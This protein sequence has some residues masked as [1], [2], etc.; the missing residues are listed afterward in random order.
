M[1]EGSKQRRRHLH[2]RAISLSIWSFVY[3]LPLL[4]LNA[5][6][7]VCLTDSMSH[8]TH[9][10]SQQFCPHPSYHAQSTVCTVCLIWCCKFCA[11]VSGRMCVRLSQFVHFSCMSWR[12]HFVASGELTRRLPPDPVDS[13]HPGLSWYACRVALTWG[14]QKSRR[15]GRRQRTEGPAGNEW[16]WWLG[17]SCW[18]QH[19]PSTNPNLG[20]GSGSHMD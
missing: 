7:C 13:D 10:T 6:L 9:Q 17:P 1:H 5:D 11:C 4:H 8:W 18:P 3:N 2:N 16:L 19:S 12:E 15:M 14:G 20:P